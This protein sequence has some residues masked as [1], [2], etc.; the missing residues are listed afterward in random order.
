MPGEHRWLD[1]VEQLARD[2][3]PPA[4]FRYLAEGARDEVTL[5]EAPEAW[6]SYRLAPRVLRDVSAV[7]PSV[8]LLGEAHPLPLGVAPMT[9]QKAA[10]FF[11][12]EG[13]LP[14]ALDVA[15]AFDFSLSAGAAE[16]A[17][18]LPADLTVGQR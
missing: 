4:V 17:R 15:P 11:H 8:D 14:K 1:Q 13:V 6:R 12:G 5:R 2:A 3:L 16:V 18:Q 7:D 9:L 10:D